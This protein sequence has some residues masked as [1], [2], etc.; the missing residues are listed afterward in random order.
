MRDV[1]RREFLVS[2]TLTV[3]GVAACGCTAQRAFGARNDEEESEAPT[4]PFDAGAVTEY[5]SPGVVDR[6]AKAEKI[7]LV[8]EGNH[9]YA[10]T[11][12]CTHRHCTIKVQED[13]YKCPCHGSKFSREGKRLSGRARRSLP[14]FAIHVNEQ[15][16]VIVNRSESFE[17][18]QWGDARSFVVLKNT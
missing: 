1:N 12:I 8:T 6:F 9:L 18:K 14:R 7:F 16:H 17:E 11:A 2:V 13:H 3:A 10:P 5:T 4:G 15:G